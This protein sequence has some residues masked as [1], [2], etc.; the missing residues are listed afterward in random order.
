MDHAKILILDDERSG[1]QHLADA[2]NQTHSVNWCRNINTA[3]LELSL[4]SYDLIICSVHLLHE[5]MFDFLHQVK[6]FAN[7][8]GIPFVCFRAVESNFGKQM[9][10]QVEMAARVLGADAY[11]VVETNKDDADGLRTAI[12]QELL[13]LL[14]QCG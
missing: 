4:S 5:S 2:L 14:Q 9:D 11:I 8:R 1:V 13:P 12:E 7:S 10:I 6:D 3:M